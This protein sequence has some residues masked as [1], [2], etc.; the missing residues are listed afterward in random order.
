L[1]LA[2]PGDLLLVLGDDVTRSWKQIIY[3]N[4]EAKGDGTAKNATVTIALPQTEEFSIDD[5]I[6]IISDE[7]GV[8]IAREA[9]D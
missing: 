8:R 6:E 2:R 5:D 7:R 1:Q 3:F 4:S 9:G